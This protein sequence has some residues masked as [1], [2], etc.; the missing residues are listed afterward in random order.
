MYEREDA[1]YLCNK[2]QEMLDNR[3]EKENNG[4]VLNDED[5]GYFVAQK[6]N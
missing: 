2:F 1:A 3:R 4:H 6:H 5:I